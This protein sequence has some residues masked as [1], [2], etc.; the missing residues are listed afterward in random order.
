MNVLDSFLNRLI[1]N[2]INQVVFVI[3][4]KDERY[5]DISG[6]EANIKICGSDIIA[7]T[8]GLGHY[9]KY[10][11][12]V[13]LTWCGEN[14]NLSKNLPE[15]T[16]YHRII[17]Q[18]YVSYMN[19]CTFNYSA[20]WWD[21]ER[22]E[23]EIDFMALNGI[24]LPLF[25]VGNEKVW[26]E[27]LLTFGFSDIE[28]REF[29][30]GPAFSAWQ[31]MGNIETFAGPMPLS[32]IETHYQMGKKIMARQLEFG[33]QPIQ[34]GFAGFVPNKL[35]EKFPNANIISQKGWFGFKD[36]SLLDP[37][38]ELFKQIGTR[39]LEKQ[40]ELFGSYGFYASDPF[41][42]NTPPK[43][44]KEY[45]EDVA[46]SIIDMFEKFD[47]NYKWVMQSWSIRKD[48][49]CTV[50]KNKLLIL[51]LDGY[52]YQNN[53]Y[54]WG[55]EF[56]TGNLHNFGARNK[57][58]GDLAMLAENKYKYI[59]NE[60]A[61]IVG[62][63]LFMEGIEQN[64]IYYD[65]A[66]EMLTK[67]D[68]IDIYK[69]IEDYA[70]RRYG[71]KDKNLVEAVNILLHTAYAKGTNGVEKSSVICAR[72][73]VNIKK[74]GP[75][76][77]FSFDYGDKRLLDVIKL[78]LSS[79]SK[80]DGANYDITDF[81]RQLISNQAYFAYQE[82]SRA[83]LNRNLEAFKTL[84]TEFL[85]YFDDIDKV[86]SYRKEMSFQTWIEN[87]QKF[88]TNKGERKLYDY[89]ASALL[90]I[91]GFDE[92]SMIFDY[93]WKEWSGLISQ[94]YKK[95]WKLFLAMLENCLIYNYEYNE[96]TLKQDFQR[97][98]WRANDFY[99]ELADFECQWVRKEKVFPVNEQEDFDFVVKKMIE[100]YEINFY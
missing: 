26:Y 4:P 18:K 70:E 80:T 47:V 51:D 90:T 34:Q 66:F 32:W 28:A 67:S 72:P 56:L 81:L 7:V 41:H 39:F 24:N 55:H 27:T 92:D 50:P 69:W 10:D 78:I 94:F 25:C 17:E 42:E 49:A 5:F 65:L 79:N 77:G 46:H 52:R 59:K 87:S 19:Y 21:F 91:W 48:I 82:V 2:H 29:L 93:A 84:S 45:M 64:P 58:H 8:T 22:W 86:T 40:G 9:L 89:N 95:R 74:S 35:K 83:F 75:N 3:E 33:M 54:F 62:T 16:P 71:K 98:A 96:L 20:T 53:E 76:G 38:D 13:N 61:N 99:N 57:L 6:D 73:A 85:E 12:K 31:W 60:G 97:E 14:L 1:P 15:P 43:N 37:T 36:T 44:G 11:A 30:V 88:A 68:S 23:K 100:K 63:G